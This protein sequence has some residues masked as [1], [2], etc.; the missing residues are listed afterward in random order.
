MQYCCG[1]NAANELD[2]FIQSRPVACIPVDTDR[3]CRTVASWSVGRVDL[4][5]WLVSHGD[6]LDW[7]RYSKAKYEQEQREAEKAEI[8]IRAGSFA[9]PWDY[10]MCVKEGGNRGKR[11]DGERK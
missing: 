5:G 6:A 10:L 11:S 8:G 2:R 7:P 3:Y 4:A 1:A 9:N